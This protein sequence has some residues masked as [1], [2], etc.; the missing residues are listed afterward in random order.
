MNRKRILTFGSSLLVLPLALLL[1][2]CMLLVTGN[3]HT[4]IA[5]TLYRSGQPTPHRIDEYARSYGI[6]T[7][8]NLRGA[9][10]GASWY[11]QEVAEAKRLGIAHVDFRMSSRAEL[12]Q[13]DAE[14]LVQIFETAEKPVLIHCADG[15]DRT[16]LAAALYVAAVAK[17]G[18]KAAEDQ[19]SL[20]YG[21]FAIPYG[22][23][24]PIDRTFED[25]EPWLGYHDS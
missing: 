20:R 15:S 1:Y 3:F 17:L 25:L 12:P 24:W 18:E 14:R 19:I 10:V 4:V 5:G 6:R 21:H 2:I 9:N 23:T 8:I 7:I 13:T 22:P 11:D 16:S